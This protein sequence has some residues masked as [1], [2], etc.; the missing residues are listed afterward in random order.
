MDTSQFP[1]L[2]TYLTKDG[3]TISLADEKARLTATL[4]H[5]FVEGLLTKWQQ[6]QRGE[7]P[8]DHLYGRNYTGGWKKAEHPYI[9]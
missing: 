8:Y 6:F 7:I 5:E 2:E 4:P 3:L 9:T 1:V